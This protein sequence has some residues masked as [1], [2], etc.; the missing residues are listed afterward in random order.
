MTLSHLKDKKSF[1][2]DMR[3][4]GVLC[5]LKFHSVSTFTDMKVETTCLQ[6]E[7]SKHQPLSSSFSVVSPVS[8]LLPEPGRFLVSWENDATCRGRYS[9]STA[10][11]SGVKLFTFIGLWFWGSSC[12]WDFGNFPL[13]SFLSTIFLLQWKDNSHCESYLS[14]P[15]F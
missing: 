15:N 8:L 5:F 1:N 7:H 4:E 10:R 2:D 6:W 3:M 14:E 12:S 9:C 13:H 11:S